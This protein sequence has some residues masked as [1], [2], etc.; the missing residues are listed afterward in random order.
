MKVPLL[1]EPFPCE[2]QV[3]IIM[4]KGTMVMAYVS[5]YMEIKPV[6]LM[7]WV[8]ALQNMVINH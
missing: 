3:L 1:Q 6:G 2:S 8:I 4:L 7:F 5:L